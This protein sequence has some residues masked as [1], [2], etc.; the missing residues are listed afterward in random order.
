MSLSPYS[1]P[2]FSK[3]FTLFSILYLSLCISPGSNTYAADVTLAWDSNTETDLAGYI[4]YWGTATRNYPNS[5]DV[6]NNTIHMITGLNAGPT[7]YFAVTAYDTSDNESN[8]SSEVT[9]TVPAVDTDGDGISDDDENNIYGTNPNLA[10]TDADGVADGAELSYW[11][12]NWDGDSDGDGLVNLL[13]PDSDNDGFLDGNDPAPADPTLPFIDTDGDGISDD[14][15]N[16]IYGT[17]PNLADTDADGVD[18]GVELSYWGNNWNGDPDGDGVINLLD[19]DSDNDGILD[20]NDAAPGAYN[21]KPLTPELESPAN[22][23]SSS[24]MTASLVTKDFS[25]PDIDDYHAQTQWQIFRTSDN[26]CVFDL[27]TDL[28]LITID[29]PMLILDDGISY[30]WRV[31]FYDNQGAAS[32]WSQ[33]FTFT[34]I[35]SGNDLNDDGIPDDKAVDNS[36]DLDSDGVPDNSQKNLIKSLNAADGNGQLGVSIRNVGAV[37]SIKAMEVVGLEQIA[38]TIKKPQEM[39]LGLVCFKLLLNNPGSTVD[40]K[41]FF[42]EYM[43]EDAKWFKYDAVNGWDDYSA[44]IAYSNDR[45]SVVVS[46]EDGGFGDADGT[47]NGIIVDPAGFATIFGG[48]SGDD[49]LQ[50]GCFI[51]TAAYG[52]DMEKHVTVLR[53][54]RDK[55]LLSYVW[56][57]AAV[58]FY[59][60]HSPPLADFIAKHENLKTVV[61]WGL[62]PF[63]GLSWVGLKIGFW[64]TL[65]AFTLLIV[66]IISFSG[67]FYRSVFNTRK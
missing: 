50:Q 58:K 18:D 5:I 26:L 62:L 47:V 2:K 42:S 63:I 7:Y 3:Y 66:F 8:Y 6:G 9:Y 20:G 32:N 33:A 53:N 46:L 30:Y 17:N 45:K 67:A 12:N 23:G 14:D 64:P 44:N 37:D 59:Y 15:E 49:A 35:I 28:F 24:S 10:D 34:T 41:V 39:P 65:A 43:P 31:R 48:G 21:N 54:F 52:S 61:R 19:P 40:I 57:T 36:V 4:V 29:V 13:D 1:L 25:D 60:K 11:G 51:A 27:T 22:N 38:D 16:N 56:G 55:I